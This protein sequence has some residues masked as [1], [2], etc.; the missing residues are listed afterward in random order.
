[1]GTGLDFMSLLSDLPVSL[2]SLPGM[3][4]P[5]DVYVAILKSRNV[6]K[7]VIDDLDLRKV[8]KTS[9]Y[10][11]ALQTLDGLTKID[12]TEENIIVISTT[13]RNRKLAAEMARAYVRHLDRVNRTTRITSAKYTRKFIEKRLEEAEADLQNA[14]EALKNFQETHKVISIEEQTKAAIE[15]EAQLEAQIAL[16]EIAYN[17]AKQT[18]DTTHPEVKRLGLKLDEMKKQVAKLVTGAGLDSTS[19]FVPLDKLPDLGLQYAFLL[20]D[21][22]VQKAIYKLLVQQY[23]QAKIQ[24]AKDTPTIQILDKP[25]EPEKRSKP[26]RALIVISAAILSVFISIF[27]IFIAEYLR[28]LQQNDPSTYQ[29]FMA[30]LYTLKRDLRLGKK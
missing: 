2:P 29:K 21:L 23:E 6:R 4:G 17:M 22:E 26:K 13:A 12:K 14:A 3:S 11:D 1:M 5:S 9:T 15:T 7:A 19:Y 20:R 30:S 25:E 24:E 16:T 28:R 27:I 18:M 10:E 8:Y